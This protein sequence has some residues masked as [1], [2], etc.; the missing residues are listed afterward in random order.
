MENEEIDQLIW[1]VRGYWLDGSVPIPKKKLALPQI[2]TATIT[3]SSSL[4]KD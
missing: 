1:D 4:I 2:S 3:N